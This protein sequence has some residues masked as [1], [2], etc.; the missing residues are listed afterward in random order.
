MQPTRFPEANRKLTLPGE[1]SAPLWI[2]TDGQACISCWRLNWRDRL[3]ALLHGRV[4][5][6]VFS[7]A[8]TQAPVSLECRETPFTSSRLE[9]G[10][11]AATERRARAAGEACGRCGLPGGRHAA[12]CP[13][14]DAGRDDGGR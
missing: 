4:W 6:W 14:A 1:D 5:L 2:H 8:V 7:G 12:W 9:A 13:S 3:R 10:R 11:E